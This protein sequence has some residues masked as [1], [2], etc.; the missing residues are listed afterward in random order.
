MATVARPGQTPLS[1]YSAPSNGVNS[2]GPSGPSAIQ[3]LSITLFT[4]ETLLGRSTSHSKERLFQALSSEEIE[5][6][7]RRNFD[8]AAVMTLLESTL[9]PQ[10]LRRKTVVFD[11]PKHWKTRNTF[12]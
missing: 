2:D 9:P 7:K 12:S 10:V 4:T 6:C 8:L 11:T 5:Q 3:S 1:Q